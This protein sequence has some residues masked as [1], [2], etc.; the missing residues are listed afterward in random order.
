MTNHKL[1]NGCDT[2]DIINLFYVLCIIHFLEVCRSHKTDNL[3]DVI[4]YANIRVI[5]SSA[6]TIDISNEMLSKNEDLMP[7]S[8]E[9]KKEQ[10]DVDKEEMNLNDEE[11]PEVEK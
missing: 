11:E 7:A 5:F 3:R 10:E 9:N 6:G 2:C 8:N 1:K 4:C